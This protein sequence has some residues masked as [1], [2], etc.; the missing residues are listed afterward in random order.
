LFLPLSEDGEHVS[1]ILVFG[2]FSPGPKP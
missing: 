1:R 2:T